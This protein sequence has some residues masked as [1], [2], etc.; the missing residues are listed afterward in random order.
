MTKCF[1]F[2]IDGTIA[3]IAPRLHLIKSDMKDWKEFKAHAAEDDVHW[4]VATVLRAICSVGWPVIL[5]TGRTEDERRVTEEWLA[6]KLSVQLGFPNDVV[7]MY[8]RSS[9]DYRDDSIVK[10]ELLERIK[11]DGWE[12]VAWFDDR[13]RVVDALRANGVN[14]F[15]VRPGDF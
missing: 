4:E 11:R 3:D 6:D 7:K 1:V 14:V 10:V 2:D 9:E 5:C 8:M 15:Q 12:I 13:K